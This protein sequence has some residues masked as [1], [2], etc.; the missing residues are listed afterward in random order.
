M[1]SKDRW[2]EILEALNANKARTL[3][4]AFGVFWGILILVLLLAL[5]NGLRTG[6][7]LD[8]ANGATNTL[9]MWGQTTSIPYNGLNKGREVQFRL[10]DVE[11]IKSQVPDL[12]YISP[13][14]Q[15]GGFRGANNVSRN[16]K[17]GAFQIYGDYPEYIYQEYMDILE[18]RFINYSDINKK[19]KTCVIG[20]DVVKALFDIGEKPLGQ[21]ITIQGVNF[22]IVGIFKNPNVNGDSEE[23]ANTIFIPFTTFKKSFNTPEEVGWMAITAHDQTSITL[24]KP[25]IISVMKKQQSIHPD[26]DR[27]IGNFDKAEMF[28]RFTGLFDILSFVGY[29]VGAL[30]LLS[31]GIGISNIMLIVVKERTNE[32]GIRRALGATPWNI[33]SQILQ[34]SLVLTIVAGLAGIATAA[35]LIFLM[36][37]LLAENGPVEN[38]ANPTVDIRVIFIALLILIIAGL[39]AGFIPASRATQVKP[40]DALRT[41]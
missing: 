38:F 9:F 22:K 4:T 39:L 13:R 24:L 34:E 37:S 6:V 2:S 10:K 11:A 26:D 7:T 1:F 25:Q 15:L 28:E 18:G 3:L 8:F 16:E 41:E 32:I 17:T 5:T 36:N 19:L 35:G 40:I 30:V 14:L 21:Y 27:A 12:K 29:F 33:K 31:G 20:T 23:Q